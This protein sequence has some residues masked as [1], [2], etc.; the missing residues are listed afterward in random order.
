MASLVSGGA[1][2][3]VMF[4]GLFDAVKQTSASDEVDISDISS[5]MQVRHVLA[6]N[7]ERASFPILRFTENPKTNVTEKSR[8]IEAWFVGAH[9]DMG[10]GSLHDG[11]SLYPFQWMLIESRDLGLEFEYSPKSHVAKNLIQNPLELAFPKPQPIITAPDQGND[12]TGPDSTDSDDE[13][14][15][16]IYKYSSGLEVSM[17]NLRHSHQHGNLQEVEVKARKLLKTTGAPSG[18][19]L[20]RINYGIFGRLSLG[21][22]RIFGSDSFGDLL[23]YDTS[24]KQY[25]CLSFLLALDVVLTCLLTKRLVELLST[26]PYT[27]FWTRMPLLV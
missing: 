1:S 24:R 25:M 14:Q 11:L 22:R 21:K 17:F 23:D 2:P 12:G 10:G 7:E 13:P 4:L 6:L 18:T 3:N 26:H 19:H 27:S 8:Y 9:A 20:V 15:P 16:W 5:T